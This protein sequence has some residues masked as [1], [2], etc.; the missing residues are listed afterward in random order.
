MPLALRSL[1]KS[2][3]F[4]LTVILTLALGIGANT[5]IYS[6]VHAVLL[7]PLAYRDADRL[8]TIQ[9][10]NLAQNLSGVGLAPAGY[11]DLE[12]QVTSFSHLAATRYN[13]TNLTRIEKPTLLTDALV[14]QDY[15]EVFGVQ[16]LLGRTFS[17]ADAAAG[18]KPV[19]VLAHSL[20]QNQFAARPDIVGRTIMLDDVP[21]TVIGV[22]PRTFKEPF[23][24]AAAWRVFPNTGGEN[25]ATTSRFWNV[26]AC[27]KPGVPRATADA[28]LATIAARLAQTDSKFYA[29]WDF[30][31][32]P[33]RDLVVGNS[34]DGLLLV[35]GAALLVLLITCANVAGLQL[36][37]AST[38]R[39]DIAIR[40]ALGASRFAIAREQFTETF[41]LVA[42]G[43]AAGVLLAR[44]GLDLL[45]ASFSGA[46]WIPRADEI[47]IN[48]P[49]LVVT[50]IAALLTGSACGLFPALRAAKV[51]AT[52]SLRDGAKG[53]A[54][55]QS[56]RL[57]SALVAG[58]VAL[59][60]V[61]LVCAGLVLKSFAT[62]LRVNPGL[63][64][65][66]TLSLGLSLPPR[67]DS[68]QKRGDYFRQIVERVN[69]TPGIES[70]AFTQTMPFT[71]GI[72]VAF[73]LAGRTDDAAKLPPA[74]LDS[75]SPSFFS[76]MRVPLVAG[77]TFAPTDRLGTPQVVVI[78]QSTAK[79]FFPNENAL[80]KIIQPP[81]TGQPVEPCEIVGIVGDIP[82]NGL[83]ADAPFQIYASMEQRPWFFATLLV[84]SAL[85]VESLA[86]T[87]QRQ[88]WSLDPDQPI[89]NIAPVRALVRARLTQPQLY[90]TL[91]SLFAALA[92]LLAALGLYGLVAYS[93]AQR[94]REFGI[95][96]ALGAQSADVTR[97]VLRQGLRLVAAGLVVGLAASFIAAR[98]MQ[99]LLFRT[100]A[101][102]PLVFV[103][104]VLVLGAVALLAALLPARRAARVDPIVALRSE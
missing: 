80:G 86:S 73:T 104:V 32:L 1:L 53:S 83:N 22:M 29:G 65:E 6:V 55:P 74:F 69:T 42:A 44:W 92:L 100:A 4:T 102:D 21:H 20:W 47:A 76:A 14:T 7:S 58:Q 103:A 3:G 94:T 19:V 50:A 87:V 28:E 62:I 8:V 39:R 68:P 96:V 37:R 91:F 89:S 95:R 78:S 49:V 16:P 26:Y 10:R 45:V 13:Y 72:P 38:R 71:W 40:L 77:R 52:D 9:S 17:P 41:L 27:L 36:V 79:K 63:E 12:R 70:A 97:L 18:A 61:L 15:F 2:P 64:V 43:A 60:L 5:A 35:V 75:V 93:V 56:T 34:R 59:T 11:R 84:R 33:L 99:S 46:W 88:I 25:F 101:Y 98:L 81:F 67:Y 30:V 31:L 24:T 82:R 90:L 57:R 54:G 85:P 51:D 23:D 66:R 48:L